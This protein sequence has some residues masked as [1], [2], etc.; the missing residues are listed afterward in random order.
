MYKLLIVDDEYNIREG[1]ANGIPWHEVDIEVVGTA[2]DGEDAYEKIEQ[3]SP[4]ILITDVSMDNMNGLDLA[5]LLK[6]K[7]PSI[8]II[9]LSGYDDFEYISK[10]LELKVFTYIIKPV[11]SDDLMDTMRKLV[12]EIEEERKLKERIHLME[13]EIDQNKSLLTERFM[14]DLINGNIENTHELEIR[15]HFLNIKF[16]RHFYTCILVEISGYHEMLRAAGIKMLQGKLFAVRS[17]LCDKLNEYELQPLTGGVGSFILLIGSYEQESDFRSNLTKE[18]E[19]IVH[20]INTLLD[21]S[22]SVSLG[23]V[24][25]EILQVSKSYKEALLTS[26]YNAMYAW[27]NIISFYDVQASNGNNYFYPVE[28]ESLIIDILN[29]N[30]EA[31]FNESISNL[32]DKMVQQKYTKNQIRISIMG[33]LSTIAKKAMEMGVDIYQI[34]SHDFIDPNS[35]LEHYSTMEQIKNWFKNLIASIKIEIRKKHAADI[36]SVIVKANAYLKEN[37]SNPLLSLTDVASHIFLNA[38]YFSRLYKNETGESFVEALTMVR[39][40]NAKELLKNSNLKISAISEKIGYPNARY[41]CS[42]FKKYTELTPLEFK[43]INQRG[44]NDDYKA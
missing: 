25:N 18:L 24:Y 1:L 34:F 19:I 16:N 28:E 35:I 4:D 11:H 38:S 5:D 39:L 30:D 33:L 43:K 29:A 2:V 13:L 3:L 41:F 23:G 12:R 32:F 42:V 37:Y 17:I 7:Y 14:Y 26:E 9:I 44:I 21:I 20:D 22:I 31:S 36:K 8:K 27:A 15:S 40:D 10:A 6:K